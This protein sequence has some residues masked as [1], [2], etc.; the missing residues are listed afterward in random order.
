MGS[1]TNFFRTKLIG[2]PE[3]LV[4]ILG[5]GLFNSCA[6]ICRFSV[7]KLKFH[8]LNAMVNHIYTFKSS[9][10]SRKRGRARSTL[11]QTNLWLQERNRMVKAAE[12]SIKW[13][14]IQRS[15][16]SKGPSMMIRSTYILFT[17]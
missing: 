12:F 17:L 2:L 11:K 13:N 10:G 15:M 6:T 8:C 14:W 1:I 9:Q 16:R 7:K 3:V 5:V 4:E